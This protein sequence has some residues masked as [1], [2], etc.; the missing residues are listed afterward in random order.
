MR[1]FD[2][3]GFLCIR[4]TL[5][6]SFSKVIGNSVTSNLWSRKQKP[7]CPCQN[8][9]I[10][11]AGWGGRRTVGRRG[12]AGRGRT[13]RRWVC[14][15]R[16]QPSRLPLKASKRTVLNVSLEAWRYEVL[17]EAMEDHSERLINSNASALRSWLLTSGSALVFPCTNLSCKVCPGTLGSSSRLPRLDL[18]SD[19]PAWT[20]VR[21]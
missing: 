12:G 19:L 2:S 13:G 14:L 17:F 16:G 6:F 1:V 21:R 4:S 18:Q 11:R 15:P 5:R 9:H 20:L 7:T 10:L 3:T 8:L